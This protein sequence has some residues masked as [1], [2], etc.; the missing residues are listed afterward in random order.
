[1][2][3]HNFPKGIS[4][5]GN[6]LIELEFKLAYCDVAIQNACHITTGHVCSNTF[7]LYFVYVN[8]NKGQENDF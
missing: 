5:K 3:V 8:A 7:Y 2:V 1:M 6:V 4:L